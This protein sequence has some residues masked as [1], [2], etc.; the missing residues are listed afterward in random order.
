MLRVTALRARERCGLGLMIRADQRLRSNVLKAISTLNAGPL[1]RPMQW[2]EGH[3][4]VHGG[5]SLTPAFYGAKGDIRCFQQDVFGFYALRAGLRG[6][7][8]AVNHL[9]AADHLITKKCYGPSV[10]CAYASAFQSL[11]G[12]LALQGRVFVDPAYWPVADDALPPD[13]RKTVLATL[14]TRNEWR[15]NIGKRTHQSRWYQLQELVTSRHSTLPS[16]YEVIFGGLYGFQGRHPPQTLEDLLSG[17]KA[18]AEPL[19][20]ILEDPARFDRRWSTTEDVLR[21]FF[22][23]IRNAR[24]GAAYESFGDDPFLTEALV[25]RDATSGDLGRHAKIFCLFASEL[26]SDTSQQWA[27][28]LQAASPSQEVRK[29]LFVSTY[30][31][32]FDSPKTLE[33]K[34]SGLRDTMIFLQHA[35]RPATG[36]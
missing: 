15:P 18:E 10:L 34:P 5:L 35:I 23:R 7:F 32:W 9:I 14:S 27:A 12:W 3:L 2:P 8:L 13:D 11:H 31:P 24:H 17:G 36:S 25:N 21:D 16:Y 22:S 28:I 30:Y 1:L 6:T 29:G 20:S 33:L 19:S 4:L 26:L